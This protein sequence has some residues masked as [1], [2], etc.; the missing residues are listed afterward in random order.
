MKIGNDDMVTRDNSQVKPRVEVTRIKRKFQQ[1]ASGMDFMLFSF[2][3]RFKN[4]MIA[5]S[6]RA[7]YVLDIYM[8]KMK[9]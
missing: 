4:N 3:N 2:G 7:L 5:T 9:R 6:A 8:K 1:I